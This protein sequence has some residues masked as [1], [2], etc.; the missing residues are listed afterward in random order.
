MSGLGKGEQYNRNIP[1]IITILAIIMSVK[2]GQ[3]KIIIEASDAED[4]IYQKE[5]S[6]KDKY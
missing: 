5:I 6:E 4:E 2:E 1:I 3:R